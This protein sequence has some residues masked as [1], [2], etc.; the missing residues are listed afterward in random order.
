MKIIELCTKNI[1]E[2]LLGEVLA[3]RTLAKPI[4]SVDRMQLAGSEGRRRPA[5]QDGLHGA[6]D[7]PGFKSAIQSYG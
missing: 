4:A 2:S 3:Q 7:W 6:L 5:R 1:L